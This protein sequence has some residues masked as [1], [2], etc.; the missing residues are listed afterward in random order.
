M[1]ISRKTD[2]GTTVQVSSF[3]WNPPLNT[4][5]FKSTALALITL[6]CTRCTYVCTDRQTTDREVMKQFSH[7]S[8]ETKDAASN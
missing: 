5:S 4:D 6:Y 3:D 8:L 2:S 7:C 1:Q